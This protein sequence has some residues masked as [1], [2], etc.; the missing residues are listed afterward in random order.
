MSKMPV[1]QDFVLPVGGVCDFAY[2]ESRHRKRSWAHSAILALAA[3]GAAAVFFAYQGYLAK[4]LVL[5]RRT[6]IDDLGPFYHSVKT[7][8]DLCVGGVSHSGHIGL[9]GDSESRPKRSFF[10]CVACISRILLL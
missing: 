1:M 10:W 6:G 9:E 7:H 8:D 4:I 3:L 2:E 5:G